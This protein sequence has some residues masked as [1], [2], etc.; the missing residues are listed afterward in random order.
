VQA[1][2]QHYGF[3]DCVSRTQPQPPP[4]SA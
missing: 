2:V 1:L 4:P 3:S